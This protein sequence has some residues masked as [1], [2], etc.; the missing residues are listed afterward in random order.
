MEVGA[1]GYCA[2]TVRSCLRRLGFDNKLCRNALKVLSTTSLTCSFKIWMCRNSKNW[3]QEYPILPHSSKSSHIN[4]SSSALTSKS[5]SQD[6]REQSISTSKVPSKSSFGSSPKVSSSLPLASISEEQ[7]CPSPVPEVTSSKVSSSLASAVL[8]TGCFSPVVKAKQNRPGII[9]KGN[10]CYVSAILQCLSVLPDLWPSNPQNNSSFV[11]SLNKMLHHLHSCKSHLDPSPFLKSLESV[12]VKAGKGPIDIFSQQD[13]VEM[14][15][16]VLQEIAESSILG[17][18][19]FNIKRLTRIT[20]HN[21]VQVNPIEDNT[22][23]LQIPVLKDFQT[24]LRKITGIES[25]IGDSAPFCYVCSQNCDSDSRTSF[26]SFGNYL[27]VQLRRFRFVEGVSSKDSSP[28]LCSSSVEVI[29]EVDGEVSVRRSFNLVAV[30]NHSGT[31]NAGHYT[32]SVQEQGAWWHCNDRAVCKSS[33]LCLNR[34][35]PYVLFYQ[36]V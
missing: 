2:N 4:S 12:L 14:L 16:V 31:L 23:M 33:N 35:L 19:V 13:V 11:L 34:S 18:E 5:K 7:V 30:I 6:I 26:A 15:E 20:C 3:S 29:L 27:I 21:C 32:C 8:S 10:T 25:L 9:N 24:S 17:N 1:R 28:F 36:A 22:S